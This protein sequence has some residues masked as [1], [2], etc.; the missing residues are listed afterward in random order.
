MKKLVFIFAAVALLPAGR[1]YAAPELSRYRA[2]TERNL[3]KPLW[4]SAQPSIRDLE[5]ERKA[6]SESA[7]VEQQKQ[8]E[9]LRNQEDARR[10]DA[11]KREIEST[12]IITGIVN[13][14]QNTLAFIK[15]RADNDKTLSLKQGETIADCAIISINTATGTV[16][17]DYQQKFQITLSLNGE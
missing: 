9:E 3:F 5:A 6:A 16:V 13:D 1:V 12:L 7:R 4:Q 14:G 17:L 11:K 10:K 15:N 8:L 2:L